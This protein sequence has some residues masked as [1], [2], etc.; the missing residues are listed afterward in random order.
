MR[1][2]NV[3]D[4]R[5]HLGFLRAN[6]AKLQRIPRLPADFSPGGDEVKASKR[7]RTLHGGGCYKFR[8]LREPRR[9]VPANHRRSLTRFRE[10]RSAREA[11]YSYEPTSYGFISIFGATS[12]RRSARPGIAN[13]RRGVKNKRM[14]GGRGILLVESTKDARRRAARDV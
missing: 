4:D 8:D 3:I 14:P 9:R 12:T 7:R 2:S 6:S 13:D 1:N 5:A 10:I 11:Y